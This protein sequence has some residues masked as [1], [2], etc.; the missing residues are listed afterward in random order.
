V[1]EQGSRDLPSHPQVSMPRVGVP[2]SAHNCAQLS[3]HHV[4]HRGGAV[5]TRAGAG[6][7]LHA[8]HIVAQTTMK[9]R[10]VMSTMTTPSVLFGPLGPSVSGRMVRRSVL[11][12]AQCNAADDR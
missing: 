4:G 11:A 1:T 2:G 6:S 7:A 9:T 8:E 5:C 12:S 10:T 3:L